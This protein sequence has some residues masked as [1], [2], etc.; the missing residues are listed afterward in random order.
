MPSFFIGLDRAS[1]AWYRMGIKAVEAL[2]ERLKKMRGVGA[3]SLLIAVVL[4]FVLLSMS[5]ANIF[6]DSELKVSMMMWQANPVLMIVIMLLFFGGFAMIV[7]GDNV[8][9][10][11][12]F[13]RKRNL[14]RI[15]KNERKRQEA[16][17]KQNERL[18]R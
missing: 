9:F 18:N 4:N 7:F 6:M 15:I 1:I 3:I 8:P 12:S 14:R 13:N 16:L 2:P 17:R 10:I 5:G 11:K